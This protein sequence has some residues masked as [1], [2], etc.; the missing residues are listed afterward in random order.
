M[1][2]KIFYANNGEALGPFSLNE[3]HGLNLPDD[4]FVWFKGMPKWEKLKNV[5][6]LISPQVHKVS[7]SLNIKLLSELQRRLKIGNRRGVHLNA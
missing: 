1:E 5:K 6:E 4:T 2:S 7:G 3:F